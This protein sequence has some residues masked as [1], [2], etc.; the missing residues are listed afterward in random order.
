MLS[1][2]L[3]QRALIAA[4]LV[5]A[6]APVVGTFLVQRKLSLMGDGIGH[7]ALTGVA[8]G[9]LV[10]TWAGLAPSRCPVRSWPRSSAR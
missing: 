9:W 10:G 8:L 5:G 1:S 7:V 6:A 2:P 3:M 4:V